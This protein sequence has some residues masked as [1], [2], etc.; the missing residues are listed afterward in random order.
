MAAAAPEAAPREAVHAS[1]VGMSGA[2][3]LGQE[4]AGLGPVWTHRPNPISWLDPA[5]GPYFAHSCIKGGAHFLLLSCP[6]SC[7]G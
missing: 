1:L 5:S 3:C 2:G 6:L 7:L 4:W